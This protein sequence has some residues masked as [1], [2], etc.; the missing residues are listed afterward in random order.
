MKD[1]KKKMY[2][3][4]EEVK[5]EEANIPGETFYQSL[6]KSLRLDEI[7]SWHSGNLNDYLLWIFV[8]MVVLIIL[9]VALW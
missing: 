2:A 3:C 7:K 4:G 9:L 6:I 8:G 5:L 1:E